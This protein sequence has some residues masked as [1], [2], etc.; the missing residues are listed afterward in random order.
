[1]FL[2]FLSL[3]SF[4]ILF[5][6]LFLTSLHISRDALITV[7]TMATNNLEPMTNGAT[8]F[9]QFRNKKRESPT[10]PL[11]KMLLLHTKNLS[12]FPVAK[13]HWEFR[14]NLKNSI[15]LCRQVLNLNFYSGFTF[16]DIKN[17]RLK[18]LKLLLDEE[19][20]IWLT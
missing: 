10:N 15:Q 9:P 12:F 11:G 5:F 14:L 4:N 13:T 8:K 2:I 1:M 17:N 18:L 3:P 19:L 16:W 7:F 20:L 6:I